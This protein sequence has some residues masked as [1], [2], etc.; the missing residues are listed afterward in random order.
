MKKLKQVI[1]DYWFRR[2]KYLCLNDGTKCRLN[3][4]LELCVRLGIGLPDLELHYEYQ[5]DYAE[6]LEKAG[7]HD[8]ARK[9][10]GDIDIGEC[11]VREVK[12]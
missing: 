8:E 5:L 1:A 12:Q 2:F 6:K 7:R 10:R 11:I 9:V 3:P 4:F